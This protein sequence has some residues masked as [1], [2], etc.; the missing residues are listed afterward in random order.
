MSQR[1]VLARALRN[2]LALLSSG[3]SAH[4]A[5]TYAT[6]F[7][8]CALTFA[9][10]F[11]AALAIA[12]LPAA[13]KTRFFALTTSL[14]AEWPKAFAAARIPVNWRRSAAQGGGFTAL[15]FGMVVRERLILSF[16]KI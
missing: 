10:R 15:H 2:G 11:F 4:G 7:L 8:V 5:A 14:S 12:A 9:H 3:Q 1:N 6:A 13:D 16:A